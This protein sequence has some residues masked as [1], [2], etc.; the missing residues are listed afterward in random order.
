[1]VADPRLVRF[2][3]EPSPQPVPKVPADTAVGSKEARANAKSLHRQL[4]DHAKLMSGQMAAVM[5]DLTE[6]A[7][8]NA[9]GPVTVVAAATVDGFPV[10]PRALDQIKDGWQAWLRTEHGQGLVATLN[11]DPYARASAQA[12]VT[13]QGAS[14]NAAQQMIASLPRVSQEGQREA[15]ASAT[16][17]LVGATDATWA[18]ARGLI[19]DG[20]RTNQTREQ[21]MGSIR[22][23]GLPQFNELRADTVARTEVMKAANAGLIDSQ[24]A[25]GDDGMGCKEWVATGDE[26]TRDWHAEADGQIVRVS[27]PFEV[28]G[29][30]LDVPGDGDADNATNC[31]C[32]VVF[33]HCPPDIG[34]RDVKAEDPKDVD[35]PEVKEPPPPT[36][37]RISDP[38]PTADA[39]TF[40]AASG[41]PDFVE[42]PN[43]VRFQ[44]MP[45]AT[46]QA[47]NYADLAFHEYDTLP[48]EVRDLTDRA[49]YKVHV[50]QGQLPDMADAFDDKFQSVDSRKWSEVPGVHTPAT[51]EVFV[52]AGDPHVGLE[53][54]YRKTMRHE[55]GHAFDKSFEKLAVMDDLASMEPAMVST[56]NKAVAGS[57]KLNP[58]FTE[59]YLGYSNRSRALKEWYAETFAVWTNSNGNVASFER[60]LRNLMRVGREAAHEIAPLLDSEFQAQLSLAKRYLAATG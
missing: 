1:M 14:K 57:P 2:V 54:F 47:R 13:Y 18:K 17:R 31:R 33:V 28:G 24:R 41:K 42:L 51:S 4:Q 22:S 6:T 35:E 45:D 38:K 56:W 48:Q 39:D 23:A 11:Y 26:R 21:I 36:E 20:L 16:N 50:S 30:L 9:L 7:I 32:T 44:S 27:E 10:D 29:E 49:G 55:M 53:N 40:K 34:K 12:Y 37:V 52:G 46:E 19:D 5:N 8:A 58:Y 15:L 59:N 60:Q 25:L 3:L 43:G